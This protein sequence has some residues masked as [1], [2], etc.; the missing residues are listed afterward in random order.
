MAVNSSIHS[1]NYKNDI[2]HILVVLDIVSAFLLTYTLWHIYRHESPLERFFVVPMSKNY[3]DITLFSWLN[4]ASYSRLSTTHGHIT[5]CKLDSV[6]YA[7]V[8]VMI[9]CFFLMWTPVLFGP[10]D[11]RPTIFGCQATDS[12]LPHVSRRNHSNHLCRPVGCLTL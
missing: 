2:F 8:C 1:W 12:I 3:Q 7:G 10:N 5:D 4:Q 6:V 11:L 9:F